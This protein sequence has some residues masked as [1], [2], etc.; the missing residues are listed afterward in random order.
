MRKQINQRH[1]NLS[2]I[3]DGE[4]T[5]ILAYDQ[6]FEHGPED[7]DIRNI[8][9]EYV[10]NIAL[11]GGF[12]AFAVQSGIAEKYHIAHYKDIKLI[13]KLNGKTKFSG[14]EPVSRQH[15]SVQR[16]LDLGA[17]A[18]GYT[19][20]LGSKEEQTMFQE[21][22]NIVEQA[23]SVGIPVVCWMYPRGSAIHND[24]STEILAYA[25][26][27]AS[28]LGADIVKLKFNGDIEGM[29]W[30]VKAAARTKVVIAGG[31]KLSD[32]DLLKYGEA[33]IKSGA[34]G[35]A[36]GRNIWQN[37]KP[38]EITKALKQIV[39]QGKTAD[40]AYSMIKK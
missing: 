11:E 37:E 6:G 29:K 9:P 40:E 18:V 22:G 38:F 27:V 7:F 3:M 12:N 14:S 5:L 28:E 32:L 16:A 36:I 30:V 24:V 21:F 25:A 2:N 13:I 20:Y 23:H 1:V 15:T 19:I 33:I 10:F 39:F 31:E 26:R 4:K 17:K 34:S 8:D 35:L